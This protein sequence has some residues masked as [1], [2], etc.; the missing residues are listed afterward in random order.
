MPRRRLVVLAALAVAGSAAAQSVYKAP[1]TSWGDPDLQG[2]YA[3]DNEYATPLERPAEFAGKTL[4][5]ITPAELAEV[6]RQATEK[7]IANL[8]P[9]PRGP[10]QWWLENLDL[11][12]RARPW[13]VVD[14]VD[15][16]IPALTPEA[17]TRVGAR[18]R[19]SF[20]GGPFDGPE[21]LN[22][23][24]RCI[25]RGV[26]GSMWP[27]AY[28]NGHQIIQTKNYIVLHSE[29]IHEARIIPLDGRPLPTPSAKSWDGDARGHWDGDT[30]VIETTNFNG[31]G[32]LAT[33][34][35][36]GRLRGIELSQAARVVER[37]TRVSEHIIQYEATINDP[38][39]YT[40][41]WTLAFPLN[42]DEPYRIFEYACHEGN[43]A[44]ENMLQLGAKP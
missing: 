10:D 29:M 32:W 31:K 40:R 24:E 37:L 26:P 7:M 9:G 12:K 3:N 19:S 44:L 16:T 30:L 11:A 8:A 17:K 35:A 22:Y 1:R 36:S 34:A 5:D 28:N 42:R 6:R 38:E 33:N 13:L 27:G 4:A 21:D 2:V 15:G 43:H 41:P 20:V 14:P 23:L 39:I 25:T 18:V